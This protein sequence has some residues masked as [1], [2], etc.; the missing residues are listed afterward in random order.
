V[1]GAWDVPVTLNA[2]ETYVAEHSDAY[3]ATLVH[4]DTIKTH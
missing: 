4:I 1:T 2:G 3:C